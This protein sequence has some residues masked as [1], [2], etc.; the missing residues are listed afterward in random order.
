MWTKLC[1]NAW[2]ESNYIEWPKC[3]TRKCLCGS[4]P[5]RVNRAQNLQCGS[6]W[7]THTRSAEQAREEEGGRRR[8]RVSVSN[9]I[10]CIYA[11]YICYSNNT[12]SLTRNR[13]V[14][15]SQIRLAFVWKAKIEKV[16]HTNADPKKPLDGMNIRCA[17]TVCRAHR[18]PVDNFYSSPQLDPDNS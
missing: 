12:H 16:R 10:Q 11:Q 8:K 1:S 7:Y 13:H 5:K 4:Q 6:N 14:H 18:C 2:I 17:L 9:W 3:P 15:F